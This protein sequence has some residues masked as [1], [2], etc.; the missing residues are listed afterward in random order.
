MIQ[1]VE[2]GE[3]GFLQNEQCCNDMLDNSKWVTYM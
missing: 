2:Q 1:S 3:K